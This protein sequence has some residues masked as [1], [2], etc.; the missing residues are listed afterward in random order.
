MLRRAKGERKLVQL[1]RE[2]EASGQECRRRSNCMQCKQG[3]QRHAG[4]MRLQN[5]GRVWLGVRQDGMVSSLV[6][7]M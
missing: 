6:S 7:G 5:L 2:K 3:I 1:V 4:A